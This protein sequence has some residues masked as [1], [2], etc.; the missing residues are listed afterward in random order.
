MI[1]LTLM[2]FSLKIGTMMLFV[3]ILFLSFIPVAGGEPIEDD[4]L[5]DVSGVK[6]A[7]VSGLVLKKNKEGKVI[8]KNNYLMGRKNGPSE[9]FYQNGKLKAVGKYVDNIRE[10]SWSWFRPSG[11]L[12]RRGQFLSGKWDGVWEWFDENGN[13]TMLKSYKSGKQQ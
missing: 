10:G 8:E 6:I 13:K 11:S 7:P 3:V 12:H 5:K 9:S 4:V 2:K 1:Y